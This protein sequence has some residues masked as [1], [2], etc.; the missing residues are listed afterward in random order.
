LG[1]GSTFSVRLP[2]AERWRV[3]VIMEALGILT[4]TR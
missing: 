4:A 2:A 1:S 3:D